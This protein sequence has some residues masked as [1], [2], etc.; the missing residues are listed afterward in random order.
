[1]Y[2]PKLAALLKRHAKSITVGWDGEAC[3]E[4]QQKIPE[5]GMS[6]TIDGPAL[7]DHVF[8]LLYSKKPL[9]SR[10]KEIMPSYSEISQGVVDYLKE[11]ERYQIDV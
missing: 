7:A 9:L 6:V 11:L 4:C 10:V 8:T 1:M 5:Q 3:N 2:V